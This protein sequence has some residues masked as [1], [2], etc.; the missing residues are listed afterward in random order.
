MPDKGP[1]RPVLLHAGFHKTGTTSLQACLDANRAALAPRW[2]VEVLSGNAALRPVTEA[3][4]RFSLTRDAVDLA[5]FQ[6][7]AA[8]WLAERPG[9]DGGLMISSE[10]FAGHMPGA[11]G[12][13]DYG[14]AVPLATAF[15]AAVQ[16][17]CGPGAALHLVY[18]T[19]AAGP[20]LRLL[21]AQHAR[22]AHLTEDRAAFAARLSAA[23][24]L[25]AMV[26]AVARALPRV[27]VDSFALED[28]ASHRLGP[29]AALL[30][31]AG[32]AEAE[33][34]AL[35]AAAPRN[36]ALPDALVDAFVAL[37]RQGLAPDALRAEK[38]RLLRQAGAPGQAQGTTIPVPARPESR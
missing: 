13:V 7:L 38:A 24:D 21:H 22:H 18:S 2:R 30:R 35:S 12:V 27:R 36:P 20:W 4:R 17:A 37:N 16:M 33:I 14:A 23:A 19:R 31:L 25:P 15:A 8:A 29:A 5:L 9:R 6:G 1:P 11:R 32:M 3:A 26:Q 10:D 34:E 28:S